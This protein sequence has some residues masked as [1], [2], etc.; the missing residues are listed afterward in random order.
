MC[1]R[2]SSLKCWVKA[3][4]IDATG[5]EVGTVILLETAAD[6]VELGGEVMFVG[7]WVQPSDARNA[8]IA[9][10]GH[11]HHVLEVYR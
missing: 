6:I 5:C 9:W 10:L 8:W 1:I 3:T 11:F 2:D 7:A 4:G